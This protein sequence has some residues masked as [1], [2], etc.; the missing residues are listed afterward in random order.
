MNRQLVAETSLT[1]LRPLGIGGRRVHD[2]WHEIESYLRSVLGERYADLFAEPV[3]GSAG[4]S[5]FAAPE[6]EVKAYSDL[7]EAQQQALVAEVEH[8][9]ATVREHIDKLGESARDSDRRLAETLERA[10]V[11][12]ERREG[13]D[14]L[15]SVE[16]EPVLV[17]WGTRDDVA[18]PPQ[19]VLQDFLRGEAL[20]ARETRVQAAAA[21]AQ[22]VA[23]QREVVE[24]FPWWWL[25]WL[26][27]GLLIAAVMYLLLL[28]CGV[29]GTGARPGL[30][31]FCPGWLAPR[32][33]NA[34]DLQREQDRGDALR[35]EILELEWRVAQVPR[36][37]RPPQARQ[38]TQ[39]AP[40]PADRERPPDEER[41][42][43]DYD[44]RLRNDDIQEGD[45]Q[46]TLIWDGDPDLD[47][48]VVCPDGTTIDYNNKNG[49]ACGGVLDVDANDKE[50]T[51]RQQP[52]ENVTWPEGRARPGRYRVIVDN[53][54]GRSAGSAPVPF[55]LR[56]KRGERVQEFEGRVAE[57]G[58]GSTV[59]EF[60][61]Q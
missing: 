12:P 47:L 41:L 20:R 7:D 23:V 40:N 44:E 60:D 50:E 57:P 1:G 3:A 32:D 29:S 49:G 4:L 52:V 35:R 17:N 43:D 22:P 42:P 45:L 19:A 37:E 51:V 48:K 15:Y 8:R 28:G 16:G 61:L 54:K 38:Q 58:P 14:F 26:L 27:F 59:H 46:I 2:S 56:I 30:L 25:L 10:V 24:V 21:A 36:C 11:V 55:R 31:D 34:G 13:R 33:A 18:E 39:L 9:F 53:Y 5:W 6:G